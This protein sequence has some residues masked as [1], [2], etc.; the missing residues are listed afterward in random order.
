M[1]KN[2]RKLSIIWIILM[3]N[4][5]TIGSATQSE[6][7]LKK[8][9]EI[10]TNGQIMD[11]VV[12]NNIAFIADDSNGF[13]IYNVS[14]SSNPIEL[15]H[16]SSTGKANGIDIVGDLAFLGILFG[17]L[18]IY[19]ISSLTSPILIG[20]YEDPGAIVD[21]HVMDNIACLSDH[22]SPQSGSGGIKLINVSDP[23][24]PFRITTFFGGGKP[25]NLF[26][27][28]KIIYSADYD[29]GYEILNASDPLNVQLI[30][31]IGHEPGYFGVYVYNDYAY[32]TN[33]NIEKGL[34]IYDM[35]DLS[36]PTLVN[37][38]SMEGDPCD[39]QVNNDIAYI[40]DG[41]TGLNV[42]NV[43]DPN[44]LVLLGQYSDGGQ[45]F[46]VEISDNIIYVVDMED[47]VEIIEMSSKNQIISGYGLGIFIAILIPIYLL[48][49]R[50]KK[51]IRT[52]TKKK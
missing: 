4:G 36:N 1:K 50:L 37:T 15:Y 32:F 38:Y 47:G 5:L 25:S 40:A 20:N 16:D 17:G 52:K 41:E 44:S 43:S 10:D 18:K 26:A 35:S 8:I 27:Q 31:T 42:I 6:F 28:N 29:F 48:Q 3:I 19:D 30:S 22:G 2:A 9:G 46:D 12:E 34:F 23:S 7:K 11:I 24:N 14:D 39:L 49:Y 13:F 45:P 33:N 21:V 51:Q